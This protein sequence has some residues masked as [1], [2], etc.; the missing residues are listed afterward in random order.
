MTEAAW[1]LGFWIS[2]SSNTDKNT[3]KIHSVV[4]CRVLGT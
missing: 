1:M 4:A 3:D 2:P